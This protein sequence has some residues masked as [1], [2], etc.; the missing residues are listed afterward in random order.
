[1]SDD[2]FYSF[3]EF[4]VYFTDFLCLSPPWTLLLLSRATREEFL[5]AIHFHNP[6]ISSSNSAITP[7][8]WINQA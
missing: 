4:H 7:I 3:Y 8:N 2:E 1:M 6:F 5:K